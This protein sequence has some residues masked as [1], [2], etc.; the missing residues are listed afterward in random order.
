MQDRTIVQYRGHT[1]RGKL[2]PCFDG[3]RG[4][5]RY[6]VD[7][8]LTHRSACVCFPIPAY[9]GNVA[10]FDKTVEALLRVTVRPGDD[11]IDGFAV[12]VIVPFQLFNTHRGTYTQALKQC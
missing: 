4:K 11:P 8:L 9:V 7:R 6:P 10:V 5:R 2:I 12:F 3:R 1:L